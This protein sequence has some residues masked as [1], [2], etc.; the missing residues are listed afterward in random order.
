MNRRRFIR[1]SSLALASVSGFGN[2]FSGMSSEE[3]SL[4]VIGTGIRGNFILRLIR[5]HFPAIR[6]AACSD[7][8]EDNLKTGLSL[9]APNA[10]AYTD[11]R[12][13]LQ[14]K[15]INAVLIATPLYLHYPIAL[16]AVESGKHVYCEK[17]M[18]FTI[19]ESKTLAK[20]INTSPIIFQVGYQQRYSPL[21]RKIRQLIRNGSCGQISHI[22]C[23]WNRNGSWRRA[24]KNPDDE[25]LINW[26]M[27][28]AYSGGLMAELSS[29]QID[30]VHMILG[31]PPLSVM[32]MGGID[33]WKDGRETYD[34]V[35]AIFEYPD[36]VKARFTALTTNAHEGFKMKFYGTRATIEVNRN[37]GQKGWIFPE[38][39][40]SN[41]AWEIDALT[42]ATQSS[43]K[44]EEGIPILVEEE[45]D[46]ELSTIAALA[47]FFKCIKD[48]THPAADV[49]AGHWGSV[50]VKMAN[51]AMET[52][53]QVDWIPDYNIG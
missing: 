3:L 19:E 52:R 42:G 32:G 50:A 9:A 22:D 17:T 25:K 27:Y 7:V 6:V 47:N 10:K 36:G 24:V 18:C 4:G 13:L 15:S 5:E 30:L 46:D 20:R 8:F 1:N 31:K 11:Y 37:D 14:D 29:H 23:Y 41:P 43:W 21:F 26:R 45:K 28:R 40:P 51:L 39:P 53:R 49:T 34:N 48:R 38:S 35:T 12:K 44:P 2:A 33:Y 16:A